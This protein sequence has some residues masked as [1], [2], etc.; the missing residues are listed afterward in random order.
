MQEVTIPDE[1]G[2]TGLLR[3]TFDRIS[4][5][6]MVLPTIL[7]TGM[8]S[9]FSQDIAIV[10]LNVNSKLKIKSGETIGLGGLRE[11]GTQLNS[12]PHQLV[13]ELQTSS[14]ALKYVN[15]NFRQDYLNFS[16]FFDI[17]LN[18]TRG[19]QSRMVKPGARYLEFQISKT[20]WLKQV[21]EPMKYANFTFIEFPI[22]EIPDKQTWSKVL[23]HIEEAESQYATGNDPGVFS[24]CYAAYEAIKPIEAHLEPI[25]NADKREAIK[26]ILV[27]MP[28][29]LNKGRHIE[30]TGVDFGEFP[31]DH[32]DAEFAIYA[33]KSSVAYLAKLVQKD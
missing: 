19:Q 13:F 7:V 33:I 25:A 15:E 10:P 8:A 3:I 16:L 21:L 24:R 23:K 2:A 5:E 11:C 26:S 18:V 9:T 30:K 31:V 4:G 20:D 27:S 14:R 28:R 29:F 1:T 17:L 32:R 6:G 12:Y 22:P